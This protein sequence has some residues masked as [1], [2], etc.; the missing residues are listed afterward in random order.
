MLLPEKPIGKLE[1]GEGVRWVTRSPGRCQAWLPSPP[2]QLSK[3]TVPCCGT[4]VSK[5]PVLPE[6]EPQTLPYPRDTKSQQGVPQWV[7]CAG[8]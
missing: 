5:G 2:G 6:Q 1:S 8:Q 7:L 4:P 3:G